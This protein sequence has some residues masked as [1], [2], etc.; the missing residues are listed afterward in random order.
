MLVEEKWVK[1]PPEIA[2]ICVGFTQFSGIC[3]GLEPPKTNGYATA[4]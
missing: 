1:S 2:Q 3:L 4:T